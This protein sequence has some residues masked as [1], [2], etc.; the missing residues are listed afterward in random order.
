MELVFQATKKGSL[1][2]FENASVVLER[3]KRDL[4]CLSTDRD[5]LSMSRNC[6][7]TSSFCLGPLASMRVCGRSLL[8]SPL[9]A[10]LKLPRERAPWAALAHGRR[11]NPPALRAGLH[12]QP[13][14]G[15][16][17]SRRARPER[18]ATSFRAN[19]GRCRPKCALR[20]V[21]RAGSRRLCALRGDSLAWTRCWTCGA[22]RSA[23][24]AS[25]WSGCSAARGA[26]KSSPSLK[27]F[28]PACRGARRYGGAAAPTR[29]EGPPP[30]GNG[31]PGRV[32]AARRHLHTAATSS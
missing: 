14:R 23:R 22:A 5:C 17:Q 19:I 8:L 21:P 4:F 24:S 26:L 27:D 7:S 15:V 1:L 29:P 12:G 3:Q 16:G 28:L 30:L 10:R 11:P 18:R 31:G 9:R 6:L 2:S 25:R 20:V 13:L 32:A